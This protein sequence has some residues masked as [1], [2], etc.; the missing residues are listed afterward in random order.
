MTD[1]I[2]RYLTH[3][4]RERG[5]SPRTVE[6]YRIDLRQLCDHLRGQMGR[7]PS[8]PEVDRTAVRA[9]LGR[10]VRAGF[11]KRS[12]ARKL[13]AVRSLFGHL[14]RQGAVPSDPTAG[15]RSPKPERR[16]PRFLDEEEARIA[17]EMPYPEDASGSRDRAIL[18]L[19][20]GGGVRLGELSG[21]D[22]DAL[23]VEGG[24]ARVLGK[25]GKERIVPI[26]RK[27]SEALRLYLDR[28]PG[29]IPPGVPDERALFLNPR[30]R[31]LSDRGIQGIVSRRLLRATGRRLGPHALRH[32]FAT[33][34]L[35]AGADLN[36]VK[37]LLG[38]V[39]LSTTQV[40]THVSVEHLKKVY[41]QA[42][43]R[44]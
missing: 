7:T 8:P 19:F 25:G 2:Q 36:A 18:E 26:G 30:G 5:F 15:L 3:L 21:L 44:A 31:R 6:A 41:R 29:L 1:A 27:A 43:P 38:H 14:A 39:S 33:H 17:V 42:H 28:R 12:I 32:S 11:K 22:L 35:N 24:T 20:Y 4:A 13:T 9:F 37:D 23:D 10:L 16:L 40:Y 34:L